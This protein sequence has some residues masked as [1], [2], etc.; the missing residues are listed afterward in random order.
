MTNRELSPVHPGAFSLTFK[1]AW[2]G[3]S[4]ETG[5]KA[6][7]TTSANGPAAVGAF[8]EGLPVRLIATLR[9][10]FKTCGP[11]EEL[12]AVAARNHEAFDYLPVVERERIIGL[13]K[14]VDRA[15]S[16][17]LVRHKMDPLSEANLIGADASLLTFVRGADEHGCRLVVSGERIFGLVSLSDLQRLPVRAA[18][19]GMVTHLE[20]EMM[21]AIQREFSYSDEWIERL[22][23]GRQT[24]INEEVQKAKSEDV[25]VDR[26]LFTQFIDKVIIIR[27]SPSFL[28]S[29]DTF[30]DDL[31]QVQSLRDKVAHANDYAT[32]EETATQVCKTVRLMDHW[33]AE[34]ADWRGPYARS[35]ASVK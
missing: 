14:L 31:R 24:K 5:A 26:L 21:K 3:M 15:D 11:D 22:P 7:A 33:I 32:T 19:F 30:E 2:S 16:S 18:L 10:E 23:P 6:W 29:G 12:E 1:K 4:T 28:F 17:G 9:S 20:S 35:G 13:L 34:L 27:K 25:F 8:E